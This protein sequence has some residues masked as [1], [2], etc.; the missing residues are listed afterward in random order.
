MILESE[1]KETKA[2]ADPSSG[3]VLLL[4]VRLSI[5]REGRTLT[6]KPS[7]Y[8]YLCLPL[9][10][11]AQHETCTL[12]DDLVTSLPRPHP[13]PWAYA[14]LYKEAESTVIGA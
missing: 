12:G 2:R 8:Y 6:R 13:M 7:M 11:K 4:L 1:T 5:L 14:P 3:K 9:G 10:A